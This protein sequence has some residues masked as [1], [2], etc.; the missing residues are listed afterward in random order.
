MLNYYVIYTCNVNIQ[1]NNHI[2][3]LVYSYIVQLYLD[4]NLYNQPRKTQQVHS[5]SGPVM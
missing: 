3:I 4:S 1:F 2:I 5:L